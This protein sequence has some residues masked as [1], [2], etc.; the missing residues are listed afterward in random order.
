M[1]KLFTILIIIFGFNVSSVLSAQEKLFEKVTTFS[2]KMK[3]DQLNDIYT[4]EWIT[5]IV[6]KNYKVT[7]DK[8]FISAVNKDINK[9]K[10]DKNK[11]TFK[12]KIKNQNDLD[13][14]VKHTFFKTTK[15]I[16]ITIYVPAYAYLGPYPE[17]KIKKEDANLWG[18]CE[19]LKLKTAAIKV[20][21]NSSP[22]LSETSKKIDANKI[23]E[24]KL[25]EEMKLK[26]LQEEK[27]RLEAKIKAEKLEEEN[28]KLKAKLEIQKAAKEKAIREERIKAKKLA[29]EQRKKKAFI[30]EQKRKEAK[31]K[32]E[33]EERKQKILAEK[34]KAK[35]KARKEKLAMFRLNS[36]DFIED[37][38]LY[39]KQPN[40]LDIFKIQKLLSDFL[41][42]KDM[43]WNKQKY[44][45]FEKLYDEA[46][47]DENFNL[48]NKRQ[49]QD[50]KER[51]KRANENIVLFLKNSLNIFQKHISS[52]LGTNSADEATNLAADANF[53][54][55]NYDAKKAIQLVNRINKWK[56]INKIEDSF[57]FN[58]EATELIIKINSIILKKQR[59]AEEKLQAKQLAEE[60]RK[61]EAKK[62][63]EE[64]RK[65]RILA[66]KKRQAQLQKNTKVIQSMNKNLNEYYNNQ[67]NSLRNSDGNSYTLFYCE[68]I[69][70]QPAK[71]KKFARK[72]F[73]AWIENDD[74][75][76]NNIVNSNSN[77]TIQ[78]K[79]QDN[80][81]RCNKFEY[82]RGANTNSDYIL[83]AVSEKSYIHYF[84]FFAVPENYCP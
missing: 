1:K 70:W 3:Y 6:P 38:K 7:F 30:A 19:E 64:D 15:K 20:D 49:N 60:Q 32:K 29:E 56:K 4:R 13:S 50:R 35:E 34:R 42:F 68:T 5:R 72:A 37:L 69:A 61:K 51:I 44:A 82:I 12:Y 54:I 25:E 10:I 67:K 24:K 27:T 16:N 11:I 55:E 8:S 66:E 75:K 2:C 84:W 23:K 57:K 83:K 79:A 43:K 74:Y 65:Q 39:V 78:N 21:K 59:L 22:K 73:Q 26:K 36:G 28:A 52:N 63:K 17:Y 77:C 41:S 71:Y 47:K 18:N 80:E 45:T 9:F 46:I 48:Y 33:E 14:F 76:F 31:K 62:K 53:L 40:E 81:W 58:D